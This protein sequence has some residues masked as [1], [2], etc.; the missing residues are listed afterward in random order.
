VAGGAGGLADGWN[1]DSS[2]APNFTKDYNVDLQRQGQRWGWRRFYWRRGAVGGAGRNICDYEGRKRTTNAK[3]SSRR[4]AGSRIP[5]RP[6]GPGTW[7]SAILLGATGLVLSPLG[8]KLGFRRDYAHPG[9]VLDLTGHEVTFAHGDN[10]TMGK[11]WSHSYD[12]SCR[13]EPVASSE[14]NGH[15]RRDLL[16]L[17]ANGGGLFSL[18]R[19]F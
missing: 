11:R 6:K 5:Q 13:G 4:L 17:G 10:S 1:V 12:I 3:D 16:T 19:I 7:D 2:T 15:R 18:K 9:S 8:E 14:A